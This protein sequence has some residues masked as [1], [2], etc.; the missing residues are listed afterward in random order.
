[1][2]FIGFALVE[3]DNIGISELILVPFFLDG[4]PIDAPTIDKQAAF[5]A[6]KKNAVIAATINN[7][8]HTAVKL[9]LHSK[10]LRSVVAIV[11]RRIA[12]LEGYRVL[13]VAAVDFDGTLTLCVFAESPLG[14][15][16]MVCT[17]VGKLAA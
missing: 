2:A 17:P 3:S 12:I 16:D 9:A 14:N 13:G 10:V 8:F 4:L 6:L 11:Y 1:M 5:C 7:H 15:I